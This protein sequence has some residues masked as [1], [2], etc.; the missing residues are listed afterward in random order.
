M[1][2]LRAPR[3]GRSA[4]SLH[5]GLLNRHRVGES[6]FGEHVVNR[7][8]RSLLGSRGARNGR[9]FHRHLHRHRTPAE[10]RQHIRC[11]ERVERLKHFRLD[12]QRGESRFRVGRLHD[13]RADKHDALSVDSGPPRIAGASARASVRSPR[14]PPGVCHPLAEPRARRVGGW[15]LTLPRSLRSLPLPYKERGGERYGSLLTSFPGKGLGIRF[16]EQPAQLRDIRGTAKMYP[17]AA[18]R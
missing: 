13:R 8:A 15:A 14:S 4:A 7:H 5:R 6:A 3:V 1:S 12:R 18:A 16:R 11:L 10:S 17:E 2:S 9:S